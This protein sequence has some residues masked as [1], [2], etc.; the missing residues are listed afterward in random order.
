MVKLGSFLFSLHLVSASFDFIEKRCHSDA[1]TDVMDRPAGPA[2]TTPNT[3]TA[4][5]APLIAQ[6]THVAVFQNGNAEY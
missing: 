2:A 3:S 5:A 4:A 6:L 1:G